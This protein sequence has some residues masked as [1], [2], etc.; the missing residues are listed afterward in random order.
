MLQDLAGQLTVEDFAA[1]AESD[2]PIA[3]KTVVFTGTLQR[4]TRSEAKARAEALGAK[5]SGSISKKTNFVV[6]G[7]KAGSKA[8]KAQELGV[9]ALSEEAWLDM[10]G[11]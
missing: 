10:I 8:A 2:S 11:T 5:V 1:S 7:E 6:I 4:M 3:G 9:T